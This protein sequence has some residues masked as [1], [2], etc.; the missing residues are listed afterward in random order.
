M[1]NTVKPVYEAT[2]EEGT[3][4]RI[5]GADIP[6]PQLVEGELP[7]TQ[8]MD[9]ALMRGKET[10]RE[11]AKEAEL[12]SKGKQLEKDLE[13]IIDSTSRLIVEK[14]KGEKLQK[15]VK[16]TKE[17]VEDSKEALRVLPQRAREKMEEENIPESER[18]RLEASQLYGYMKDLSLSFIKSPDFREVL[19]DWVQ[20]FQSLTVENIKEVAVKKGDTQIGQAIA[21]GLQQP[22]KPP[23][24]E[25][26]RKTEERLREL[27]IKLSSNPV[28][29]NMTRDIL[30]LADALRWSLEDASENPPVELKHF[31]NAYNN[32]LNFIAEFTG[33]KD[34]DEFRR[35]CWEAYLSV[36]EDQRL[37]DWFV[38]FRNLLERILKEPEIATGPETKK[39]IEELIERG[40][41]ILQDEKWKKIFSVL[42]DQ[43]QVLLEN[44]KSDTATMEFQAKLEKF[45]KDLILNE[46]GN[47]DLYVLEDSLSQLRNLVLP[48]FKHAL[49]N[50]P[51]KKIEIISDTY[52]VKIEDLVFDATTFMPE[53]LDFR[54]LNV[55]HVDFKHSERDVLRHQL[56]IQVDH[57]KPQFKHL[58]FY[59]R[60][61]TFPTIEDYGVAD[62]GLTGE[63]AMIR[64][65]WTIESRGG[66]RPVAELSEVKCQIDKITIHIV[67]EAT[68]HNILDAIMAPLMSSVIKNKMSEL[69]EDY[70][71]AKL[72]NVTVSIND[73]FASRPTERLKERAEEMI[74]SSIEQM[75]FGP[76]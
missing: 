3:K 12:D 66:R 72:N 42:R 24:D 47:P 58:K 10:L 17:A 23:K 11:T 26:Q 35:L 29:Q 16:E 37:V 36:R 18:L 75:T 67:G 69:I 33:K 32:A 43:F 62:V 9:A 45:A 59:Y 50:I 46:R 30:K 60:R 52:D 2:F 39:E 5:E 22:E 15:F 49:E 68:K 21:E 73:F 27:L 14:N 71:R 55:S 31:R 34:L 70:L 38:D 57:I 65:L 20:F 61:K 7:S 28:Y 64:V 25:I 44:V 76:K 40:R 41:D 4:V 13:G 19:S 56:F 63:G 53:H 74:Q 54:M 48:L 8:Q 6:K 1:S 51:I